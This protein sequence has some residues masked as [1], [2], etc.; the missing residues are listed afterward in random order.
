MVGA[1]VA[2]PLV[3]SADSQW[4]LY[5]SNDVLRLYDRASGSLRTL[6]NLPDLKAFGEVP[7][8]Q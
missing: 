1:A 7:P 3:W 8:F 4:A 5:L 6:D 2:S